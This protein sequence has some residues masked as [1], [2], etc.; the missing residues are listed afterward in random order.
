[1]GGTLG[2]R[3]SS[4]AASEMVGGIMGKAIQPKK[5]TK[6]HPGALIHK[7]RRK[8]IEYCIPQVA[9]FSENLR[10]CSPEYCKMTITVEILLCTHLF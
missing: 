1:M 10:C 2:V 8:Y 6:S 7:E 4:E 5:R 3:T 9:W